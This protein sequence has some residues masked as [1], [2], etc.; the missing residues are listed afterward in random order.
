MLGAMYGLMQAV[1]VDDGSSAVAALSIGLV[2]SAFAF[3]VRHGF[4]WD[5]IVAIA[6]LSGSAANR[7][8]GLALSMMYAVG[9]GVVVL[10]IGFAIIAIGASLPDQVASVLDAWMGR[11]V[12]ATLFG[13]GLWILIELIRNGRD[14]RLRSRWMLVLQ[15]TFAGMRR[16]HRSFDRVTRRQS[17][18][19]EVEHVHDHGH[20]DDSH[21]DR[22]AHDHPH[23]TA[24]AEV[25]V[26]AL[27]PVATSQTDTSQSDTSQSDVLAGAMGGLRHSHSH[28]H[29]HRHSHRL[30]LSDVGGGT[31][32]GIGVLHGVGIESPTQIAVFTASTA[33]GG[34]AAAA[35][36]LMAWVV[37]LI[38]ANGILAVA[39][40]FGL[41]QA[42][43]YFALYAA[44]AV[45]VAVLSMVM[46]AVLIAGLEPLALF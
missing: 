11:V 2:I 36:L 12:G 37:G 41:L 24:D 17:R 15:G 14:F 23:E 35:V 42:E 13:L 31:A 32:V 25:P 10:G 27:A 5:H 6:D 9:H 39:A 45:V 7:R 38:V 22:Q 16:V 40:G 20:V 1:A 3:G 34:T 44:V 30:A 19:L 26:R 33:V 28:R 43:R 8:R 29:N 18:H 21:N 46:G 4:D